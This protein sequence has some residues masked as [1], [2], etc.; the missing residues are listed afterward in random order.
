MSRLRS[1]RRPPASGEG[2]ADSSASVYGWRGRADHL[3]Q[4]RHARR[5]P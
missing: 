5:T 2:A 4:F 3:Q 1:L